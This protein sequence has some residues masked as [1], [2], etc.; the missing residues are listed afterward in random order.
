MG[1]LSDYERMA[2]GSLPVIIGTGGSIV[3]HSPGVGSF[4]FDAKGKLLTTAPV[5]P[6]E[7]DPPHVSRDRYGYRYDNSRCECGDG[8]DVHG[9]DGRCQSGDDDGDGYFDQWGFSRSSGRVSVGECCCRPVS[10][11]LTRIGATR[12]PMSRVATGVI[13]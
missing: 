13:T 5:T 8:R 9:A 7:D 11:S 4:V 2:N 10:S 1:E 12:S 6:F 3:M